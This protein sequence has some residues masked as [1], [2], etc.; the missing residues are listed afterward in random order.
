MAAVLDEAMGATAWISGY[1]VLAASIQ[2]DFKAKLPLG[3]DA[4]ME[5]WIDSTDG[6]KVFT[7]A[8]LY[9]STTSAVF[10]TGSGVFVCIDPEKMGASENLSALAEA[11]GIS[12]QETRDKSA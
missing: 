9:D 8:R 10:A 12:L 11:N 6:R 3:T 2:V 1:P 4:T 5:S 7:E